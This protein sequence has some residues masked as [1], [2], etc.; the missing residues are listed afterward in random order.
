MN[1]ES[2]ENERMLYVIRVADK[3]IGDIEKCPEAKHSPTLKGFI[4]QRRFLL[5]YI[6]QLLKEQNS[7]D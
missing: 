6:D 2:P 5:N 3:Y 4:E 1:R 7:N